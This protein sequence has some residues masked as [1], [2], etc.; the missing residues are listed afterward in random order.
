MEIEN[1][2]ENEGKSGWFNRENSKKSDS[3][4][5]GLAARGIKT[6]RREK[7]DRELEELRQLSEQGELTWADFEEV[8]GTDAEKKLQELIDKDQVEFDGYELEEA[9]RRKRYG[10]GWVNF[11]G[12]AVAVERTT[13][14]KL[15]SY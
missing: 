2:L 4:R 8:C 15:L 14:I 1:E 12:K 9:G 10:E 13:P 11:E 7:V 5:H 6:A 3:I